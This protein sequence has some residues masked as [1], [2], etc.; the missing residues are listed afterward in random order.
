MRR[1]S[2]LCL[3]AT[4]SS[5]A[6]LRDT[7]SVRNSSPRFAGSPSRARSESLAGGNAPP[8]PR[9]RGNAR[10]TR[11]RPLANPAPADVHAANCSHMWRMI[12]NHSAMAN[13][14]MLDRAVHQKLRVKE[15]LAFSVC[16]DTTMCAVSPTEIP[17]LMLEY[18]IAFTKVSETGEFLC[19]A[20][21]G[22]D[23]KKNL[24]WRGGKWQSQVLPLNIG[25]QPFYVGMSAHAPTADAPQNLVTYID[26]DNPAVQESE[27][28]LLFDSDGNETPYLK[29]KMATLSE[30]IDGERRAKAFSDR[31]AALDLLRPIQLEL[32]T[33]GG[34]PRQIGGLY[35]VDDAKLRAIGIE[36]LSEL[37]TK[38]YLHVIH[39]VLLSLGQLPLLARR[40]TSD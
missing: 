32:N 30:L 2:R 38:G 33:P 20:L 8:D 17:R 6:R 11:T 29:H 21:F 26:L 22:V 34:Q 40:A 5:M 13:L 1:V 36:V 18:P 31:L 39:A 10:V 27:G 35:S 24:F 16:K 4:D 15:E 9:W 28:D 14:V 37:N 7:A 3:L 23:P 25:R 19:V 12:C